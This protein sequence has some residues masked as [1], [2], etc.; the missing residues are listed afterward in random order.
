MRMLTG[1]TVL[2]LCHILIY[3]SN[4]LIKAQPPYPFYVCQNDTTYIPNSPYSTNLATALSSLPTTNT[5]NGYFNSSAGQG[6]D[7]ANA[8]CLCRGDVERSMCLGCLRDAIFRLRVV[9]PNQREAV[10]YYEFCLLKYSNAT[11][12]GNND[13]TRDVYRMQ[14]QNTFPDKTQLYGFLNPFMDKLRD[15][16]AAGNSLL[17]FGMEDTPGPR[18]STIYGLTQ[19]IPVITKAQCDECLVNAINQLPLC[20]DGSLGAL[21]LMARCNIRYE[22]YEFYINP[23]IHSPPSVSQSSPSGKKS[24]STRTIII[25]TISAVGAIVIVSIC[26]FIVLIRRKN[27][28]VK[29]GEIKILVSSLTSN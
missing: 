26:I 28:L 9:C 7:R 21:V 8:V 4:F 24:S 1:N 25:V 16:A 2:L 3:L 20:C 5:G 18:S 27:I 11:L 17:K 22:T 10:I 14:N 12:L 13:M 23:A 19:C 29:K 15:K 6:S